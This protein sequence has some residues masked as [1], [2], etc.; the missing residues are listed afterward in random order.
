MKL[1]KTEKIQFVYN[2]I[3]TTLNIKFRGKL[4]GIIPL[5]YNDSIKDYEIINVA[6]DEYFMICNSNF[7]NIVDIMDK[8]TRL[9]LETNIDKII[10][11]HLI[12]W[13]GDKKVLGWIEKNKYLSDERKRSRAEFIRHQLICDKKIKIPN[14]QKII[15]NLKFVEINEIESETVQ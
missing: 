14:M 5:Y 6:D 8:I 10:D 7:K 1:N 2:G 12:E 13:F 15:N 11:L 9:A 4:F 3:N